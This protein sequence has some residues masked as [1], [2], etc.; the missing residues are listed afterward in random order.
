MHLFKKI[1]VV[2]LISISSLLVFGCRS[3]QSSNKTSTFD[4]SSESGTV[5]DI[6]NTTTQP[7]LSSETNLAQETTPSNS[8]HS[9]EE[10][11]TFPQ[12]TIDSEVLISN[13]GKSNS[14]TY[15]NPPVSSI[16]CTNY[17]YY[18]QGVSYNGKEIYGQVFL[19]KNY[20]SGAIPTVIISHGIGSNYEGN[21]MCAKIL[22]SAGYAAYC[23]DFCGGSP[24]SKSSGTMQDM[25]ILTEKED[26]N[27]VIAMIL[28]QPFTDKNHLFL[29]GSS[30]GGCVSAL[31]AD[32]WKDQ[33]C[34]VAYYYPAFNIPLNAQR[35]YPD[36]T[37]IPD[38]V[39]AFHFPVGKRYYEDARTV[40]IYSILRNFPKDVIMIH[41]NADSIVDITYS[42]IAY[43]NFPSSELLEL[44]NVEHNYEGD[45]EK[46]AA[47]LTL[48]FFNRH[49]VQKN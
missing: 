41:G 8:N 47:F 45:I 10:T 6:Q 22:A 16:D 23:F 4:F 2:L 13:R 40:D 49:I 38:G 3:I 15:K 20:T 35:L 34:A 18:E 26:L 32:E 21:S 9:I 44:D 33:I 43:E 37:A 17:Q 14:F 48:Q 5:S 11:T 24:I 31:A 19:P 27:A 25:S 30:Q 46:T 39:T 36:E 12:N 29:L 1:T 42:R 28:E 7:T